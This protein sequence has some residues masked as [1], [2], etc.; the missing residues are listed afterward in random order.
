MT[1]SVQARAAQR[2]QDQVGGA[3]LT[4]ED[5]DYD[6]LRRGWNLSIDQYPA[7]ILVPHH[8]QDVVAGVNFAREQGLGVAVLLTGHGIQYPADGQLLIVTSRMNKVDISPEARTARVEAGVLWQ[9]VLDQTVPYGLTPLLGTAPHI[10]VVGYTLNGG[11][12]WLARRYGFASD[13]VRWIELVTADGVL[14]RAS[15]TENSDLFWGLRGGGGNFG[16]VTAM[17]FDLFP[18]ATVYGGNL[19]YPLDVASEA[20]RFYQDWI[21]TVPDELTSIFTIF[22][23]PLLPAVPEDMRGKTV[24]LLRAAFAGAAAEG[25]RLIRAW[26]D[27]KAPLSNTFQQMPMSEVG[28]ISNQPSEPMPGYGSSEMF[29]DLSDEAIDIIVRYATAGDSP[30]MFVELRHVGG[31]MAQAPANS[32]AMSNRDALFYMG[33]GGVAPTPEVYQAIDKYVGGFREELRPYLHGAVWLNY[34]LGREMRRRSRDFYSP[35]A[36]QRLVALKKQYDPDNLFR[37]SHQLTAS[38]K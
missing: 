22:R 1:F 27:W 13:H 14:R 2:L 34:T 8:V 25:E 21:R 12:S 15:P 36:Y 11:V 20:L 6:Q 7:L 4:P 35:E 24:V 33:I 37:F 19:V 16:V 18:V 31:A 3:V 17:E 23:F 38:E 10:G 5:K 32:S 30:L 9:Q 26:L 28:S 29:N